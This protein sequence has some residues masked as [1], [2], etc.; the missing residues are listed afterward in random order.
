MLC[1]A[2][3][4]LLKVPANLLNVFVTLLI[5]T[6]LDDEFSDFGLFMIV[7]PSLI[8]CSSDSISSSI[9]RLFLLWE[10]ISMSYLDLRDLVV[11]IKCIASRIL[12]FPDPFA[13]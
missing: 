2:N 4:T 9:A 11:D 6:F 10:I 5:F 8:L 7:N 3:K 13:P 12:L 1:G